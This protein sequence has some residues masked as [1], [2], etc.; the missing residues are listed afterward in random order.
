MPKQYSV[1]REITATP[2]RVWSLLTDAD[3][4]STWNRAVVS[5]NG[6]ISKGN[7]IELVRSLAQNVRGH[8]P[9][10]GEA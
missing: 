3:S 5:I 2:E 6:P 1:T 4:Y 8:G 9:A 10:V 7:R